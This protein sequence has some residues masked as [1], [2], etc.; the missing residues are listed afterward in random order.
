MSQAASEFFRSPKGRVV[1]VALVIV[2]LAAVAYSLYSNMGS[3][4]YDLASSR[5]YMDPKTGQPFPVT[6]RQ[7]ME[8]PPKAPSGADGVPAEACY[9][10]KEGTAKE[11]PTYVLLN[12]H[13][14]K[15]EP[16]FCPDCGR[17]VKGHNPAPITGR[18]APPTKDEYDQRR[19]ARD[20]RE[21]G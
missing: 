4:A 15:P 14:G 5:V 6:V 19:D 10:T 2:G 20:A 9:W 16:T 18:K 17:L 12:S 21:R 11:E 8:M 13:V 3:P 1:A 7:G